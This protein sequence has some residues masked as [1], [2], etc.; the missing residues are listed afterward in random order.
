MLDGDFAHEEGRLVLAEAPALSSLHTVPTGEPIDF[1]DFHPR[2]S[3]TTSKELESY[4]RAF[5]YFNLLALTEEERQKLAQDPAVMA[6]LDAWIAVQAPFTW[7]ARRT[8][9]L[10]GREQKLPPY[11]RADCVPTRVKERPAHPFPLGFGIDG[12]ILESTVSRLGVAADCTTRNDEPYRKLPSGL[13]LLTGLGSVEAQ[14]R[15]QPE[16]GQHSE[17]AAVHTQL[18]AR[19]SK[20]LGAQDLGG[21]RGHFVRSWLRLVQLLSNERYLPEGVSAERWRG[22]LLE[23]ALGTWVNLRHTTVLVNEGTGAEMGGAWF[24]FELLE[25]EPPRGVIDP[26][27]EAWGHL[28]SMLEAL[29]V[30]ARPIDPGVAKELAAAAA[31]TRK[32]A[33]L[34]AQQRDGQPLGKEGYEAI[35]NYGRAI[36]HPFLKLQAALH[37]TEGIA[38][39]D[40]MIKIVDVQSWKV[41]GETQIW[42]VAVGRPQAVTVLLGDRGVLVPGH[43]AV[44]S[45]HEVI[46]ERPLDDQAFRAV[47]DQTPRPAWLPPI[48]TA[49]TP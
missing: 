24:G 42:H 21:N 35:N 6:A 10:L 31:S 46:A 28:A 8:V 3:Y 26:L 27:P 29:E 23:T 49:T 15:I 1:A 30:L 5:K 9:D 44:Y 32:Y 47:V 48:R 2:G 18:A 39:P 34:A 37:P 25:T 4:F 36:E 14:R 22:R 40:P 13:D 17:L 16:Y 45:Y 33:S 43:G 19:F 11:A 7:P 38:G 12:E 20:D 41:P